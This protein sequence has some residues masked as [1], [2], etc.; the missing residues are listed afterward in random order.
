[1]MTLD[2]FVKQNMAYINKGE[3]LDSKYF[4]AVKNIL[5]K[6][7]NFYMNIKDADQLN[8]FRLLVDNDDTVFEKGTDADYEPPATKSYWDRPDKFSFMYTSKI[9]PALRK[10]FPRVYKQ[11]FDGKNILP[12]GV[13][14]QSKKLPQLK[15]IWN[16]VAEA[17]AQN[18][19]GSS[20]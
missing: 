3:A 2:Q 4:N 10:K 20:S 8:T 1:M 6:S 19:S 13:D 5:A 17:E 7:K 16:L 18:M 15:T 14:E 11:V 12:A 9:L